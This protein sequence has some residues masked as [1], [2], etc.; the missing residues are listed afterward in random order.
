[1][2]DQLIWKLSIYILSTDITTDCTAFLIFSPPLHSPLLI[3]RALLLSAA[4]AGGVVAAWRWRWRG[5]GGAQCG[6]RRRR[7]SAAATAK[8]HAPYCLL[9]LGREFIALFLLMRPKPAGL[10]SQFSR[11]CPSA[12]QAWTFRIRAGGNRGR[13]G[14]LVTSAHPSPIFCKIER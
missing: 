14:A 12:N 2:T 13:R 3:A 11:L 1:M 6:A 9:H 8:V 7:A 4:P 10:H 5:G